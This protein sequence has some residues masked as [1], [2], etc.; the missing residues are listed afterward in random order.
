MNNLHK[1]YFKIKKCIHINPAKPSSNYKFRKKGLHHGTKNRASAVHSIQDLY[2]I[3]LQ[4]IQK[5]IKRMIIT[6]INS[7]IF[8]QQGFV[9][10]RLQQNL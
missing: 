8:L 3:H 2:V 6:S 5:S 1:Q 7:N 4:E 10:S 9:L